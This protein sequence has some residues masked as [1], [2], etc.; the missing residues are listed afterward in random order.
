MLEL[1][2]RLQPQAEAAAEREHWLRARRPERECDRALTGTSRQWLRRLP[3]RR[4]P[5]RLCMVHPRV[6]NRIAW[7]WNDPDLSRQVLQDLLVDRRGGR[8]GF[9]PGI[10]R[11]L[12]RLREFN[13]QQRMELHEETWAQALRRVVGLP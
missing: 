7:C 2:I 1:L 3:P 4:R 6:A 5:L 12:Q 8:R 9:A 10:V 13:D 11:E